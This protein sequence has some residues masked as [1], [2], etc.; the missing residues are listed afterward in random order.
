MKVAKTLFPLGMLLVAMFLG[1]CSDD[2]DGGTNYQYTVTSANFFPAGV[3]VAVVRAAVTGLCGAPAGVDVPLTRVGSG[4]VDTPGTVTFSF[5][6][7]IVSTFL[8]SLYIDNNASGNL[9]S[10]DRVWGEN[11]NDFAGA[12]FS[13]LSSPQAFDWEAIAEQIRV[14]LG[15]AQASIIYTR[16]RSIIFVRLGAGSSKGNAMGGCGSR[17]I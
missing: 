13:Q 10:G 8:E 7:G 17:R 14:A 1:A 4:T 3:Q 15:N 5:T 12:C 6:T 2:D 16:G 11:P 9:D